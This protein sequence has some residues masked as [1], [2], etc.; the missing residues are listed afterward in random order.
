MALSGHKGTDCP[1]AMASRHPGPH[2]WKGGMRPITDWQLGATS[3]D[4]QRCRF[5]VWAPHSATVD[6]HIVAPQ[7]QWVALTPGVR[8]YHHTA[9]AGVPPGS[10]V[11]LPAQWPP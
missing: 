2:A 9:V 10:L 1:G 4:E 6:V 8:G 5:L 11:L 7:E 3:L